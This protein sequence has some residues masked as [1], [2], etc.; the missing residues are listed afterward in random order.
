LSEGI[1]GREFGRESMTDGKKQ[2]AFLNKMVIDLARAFTNCISSS[3]SA[4]VKASQYF[5]VRPLYIEN[6]ILNIVPPPI[7]PCNAGRHS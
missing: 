5:N 6:F 2:W 1:A 3:S 7:D 4:I